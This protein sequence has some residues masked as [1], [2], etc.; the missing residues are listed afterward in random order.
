MKLKKI[1]EEDTITFQ[2]QAWKGVLF[3]LSSLE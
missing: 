1:F 2:T 3:I